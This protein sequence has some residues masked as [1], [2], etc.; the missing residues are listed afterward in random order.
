MSFAEENEPNSV[1][2]KGINIPILPIPSNVQAREG[3][4]SQSEDTYSSDDIPEEGDDTPGSAPEKT[5]RTSM[6][7]SHV[8]V[9]TTTVT[10]DEIYEASYEK[11]ET[12]TVSQ[13]EI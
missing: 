2:H 11:V 6:E 7:V 8:Q 10:K 9:E 1:T 5:P 12:T 4:V 13:D 3:K